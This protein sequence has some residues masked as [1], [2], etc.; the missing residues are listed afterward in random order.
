[1]VAVLGG[2]SSKYGLVRAGI[3]V[4][5][6]FLRMNKFDGSVQFVRRLRLFYPVALWISVVGP[7]YEIRG[8][9]LRN[10]ATRTA[11]GLN[12]EI[13][14]R[15]FHVGLWSVS[16]LFVCGSVELWLAG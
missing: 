7:S 14:G 2:E 12:V 15:R 1:M 13:S 3:S 4:A 9:S 5:P 16:H 10:S 11:L 8:D 6:K